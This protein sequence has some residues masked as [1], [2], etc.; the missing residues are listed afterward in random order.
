MITFN[1]I[2][3][4]KKSLFLLLAVPFFANAQNV[5]IN[6]TAPQATL[7]VRGSQRTGGIT[8]YVKY[9]SATG[10]IEWVGAS[11]FTPISQQIIKHSASSEGLYA[12]GGKLDYRNSSGTP[13]FYSDWTNG[14]GYFSGNLGIGTVSP[15]AKV[16]IR[17]GASG[18]TPFFS[19]C[20]VVET[21][22]HTYINLLSPDPFETGIL[23]GSGTN[24]ASGVISYNTTNTP[25]GFTFSDSGNLTR[26]V[27][28]QAGN[29]GMGTT[30]PS[31]KLEITHNG[32][33]V[34]GTALLINQDAVG[35]ADGPKI[36]FKKTM[37][38]S[39]SWTAG[40][41]NGID[42]GTFAIN[43]DGG[44]NGFGSPRFTIIPGGN[45]GIGTTNPLTKLHIQNGSSGN[46]SPFSPLTVESNTNTYINLLSPN[47]N[48]TSILFGRAD[49][50][51]SGGII[52]NNSSNLNGFQFRVNNNQ[53][54]VTIDNNLDMSVGMPPTASRLSV[55]QYFGNPDVIGL[56][57]LSILGGYT[58]DWHIGFGAA[59]RL[60]F[61][62]NTTQVAYVDE[63]SGA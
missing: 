6:T 12:G 39:K 57:K 53:T 18:I 40:I 52:Y 7:D 14:N 48:E 15:T 41:L 13:V 17:D 10:K 42:I 60:Y 62:A 16:Q 47:T 43:E 32:A 28:D 9:D 27:I 26:M 5:G 8:N 21:N 51:T 50:A 58:Y 19:A 61:T 55:G 59:N 29:V 46:S 30:A 25:K 34:Y 49:N 31:S 2:V 33:S 23:F 63:N 35:N 1:N 24:A 56:Y 54:A 20:V 44:T 38:A 36:Q 22:S 37:T 4:G 3:P 11:L 45:I